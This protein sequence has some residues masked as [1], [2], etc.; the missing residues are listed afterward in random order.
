M[1]IRVALL[2]DVS[3]AIDSGQP[4]FALFFDTHD[5]DGNRLVGVIDASKQGRVRSV[6]SI[7]ES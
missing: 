4:A 7:R 6:I 2:L 5:W 1:F 3:Q